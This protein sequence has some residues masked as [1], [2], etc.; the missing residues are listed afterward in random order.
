MPTQEKQQASQTVQK[1]KPNIANAGI[2][3]TD[4]LLSSGLAGLFTAAN[5]IA[6]LHHGKLSHP[7]SYDDIGYFVD[8]ASRLQ[9]FHDHNFLAMA[10]TFID[11]PPHAPLSTLLAMFGFTLFGTH[12]WAVPLVNGIW[13]FFVLLGLRL[14]L[15]AQPLAVYLAVALAVLAWPLTQFL[16]M[17]GRPDIVCGLLTAIGCFYILTAPWLDAPRRRILIAGLFAGLGL[18]AKPTIAPV[19]LG[20]FGLAALLASASDCAARR[21][22]RTTRKRFFSTNLLFLAATLLVALPYFAFGWKQTVDYIY[23]VLF[24]V[25]S[26]FGIAKL[27]PAEHASYYLW[28]AGGWAMMGAWLYITAFLLLIAGI[29]QRHWVIDNRGRVAAIAAWCVATYLAVTLPTPKT[30]FLGVIVSCTVLLLFI[31][32]FGGLLAKIADFRSHNSFRLAPIAH[33]SIVGAALVIFIAFIWHIYYRNEGRAHELASS[34]IS[35]RQF[36]LI[37]QIVDASISASSQRMII[38]LPA[39]GPYLNAEELQF[40]FLQR[41]IRNAT[42]VSLYTT[43]KIA[44]HL[45]AIAAATDVVLFEPGDPYMYSYLPSAAILPEITKKVTSDPGL[46]LEKTFES[47]DSRHHVRL[48][49]RLPPLQG[50]R[51][52]SGFLLPAR[53]NP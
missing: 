19:T 24:G 50:V 12:A 22:K 14:C 43:N 47:A 17:E 4:I 41:H 29:L 51:A 15:L 52:V 38:V 2:H 32:A 20:L 25:L 1:E 18:L 16:V 3:I 21:G 5:I 27:T 30:P 13:V 33:K 6:S 40:A 31:A 28:G 7:P 10:R 9:T 49:H 45:S 11:D 39:I 37:D 46:V 8:A 35:A 34:A 48:Y 53:T 36:A 44:D 42:A 23:S 26:T